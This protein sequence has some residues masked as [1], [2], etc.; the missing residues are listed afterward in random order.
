[1]VSFAGGT[2]DR[3]GSAYRKAELRTEEGTG[4][5]RVTILVQTSL[6]PS[7]GSEFLQRKAYSTESPK[8]KSDRRIKTEQVLPVP[9]RVLRLSHNLNETQAAGIIPG[10]RA[11]SVQCDMGILGHTVFFVPHSI[12]VE[13][14]GNTLPHFGGTCSHALGRGGINTKMSARVRSMV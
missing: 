5:P 2:K 6:T 8:M 12:T 7:L 11:I 13:L 10:S 14:W 9:W 3:R 1:M 4:Q